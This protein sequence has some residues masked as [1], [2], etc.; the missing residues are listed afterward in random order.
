MKWLSITEQTFFFLPVPVLS[1]CVE[2]R[3][4]DYIIRN[5]SADSK[6]HPYLSLHV[7]CTGVYRY[8]VHVHVYIRYIGDSGPSSGLGC[9]AKIVGAQKSMSRNRYFWVF[10][11]EQTLFK[12]INP[13]SDTSIRV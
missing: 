8:N 5:N 7:H 11:I 6:H 13:L 1:A 4:S 3:G 10:M 9:V 12:I 2:Y